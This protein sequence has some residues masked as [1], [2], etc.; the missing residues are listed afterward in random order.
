MDAYY[1]NRNSQPTGEH[2]VHKDGCQYMPEPSNRTYL[3]L[4]GSCAPAVNEARKH[5]SSVDGCYFCCRDCHTR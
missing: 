3:G 4:F 1:V 2:E 5:Y